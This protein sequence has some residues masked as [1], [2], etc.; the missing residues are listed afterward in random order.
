MGLS[1][2]HTCI[3]Q[4]GVLQEDKEKT[5]YSAIAWDSFGHLPYTLSPV[6]R[7]V[8]SLS[9]RSLDEVELTCMFLVQLVPGTLCGSTFISM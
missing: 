2:S 7:E 3:I 5:N 1:L 8:I 4:A 6:W 9:Q